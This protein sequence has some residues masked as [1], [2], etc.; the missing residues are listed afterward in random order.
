MRAAAVALLW[1]ATTA[2]AAAA[3]PQGPIVCS[4][5][6][7]VCV[8]ADVVADL[9][10][11]YAVEV[12]GSLLLRNATLR[13]A[14]CDDEACEG[15]AFS[16]SAPRGNITLERATVVAASVNFTALAL[17]VDVNSS[18]AANGMGPMAGDGGGQ[19]GAGVG[20]DGTGGGHGGAGAYVYAC[21]MDVPVAPSSG[22]GY[23]YAALAA[24]FDFGRGSTGFDHPGRQTA[25]RGGGRVWL[26]AQGR[27]LIEGVVSV[28]G[29][30][31]QSVEC[32]QSRV[33]C[34]P[35]GGSG[36]SV[37]VAGFNVTLGP[38]GSLSARGGDSADCGGGGGGLVALYAGSYVTGVAAGTVNVTGGLTLSSAGVSCPVGGTGI[39]YLQHLEE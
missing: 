37:Y 14:A 5:N 30:V 34:G 3:P 16:V 32:S 31:G 6:A 24:P 26:Q 27:A 8:V 19:P 36:G 33:A 1:V 13:G 11:G 23:G 7:T 35:G 25:S 28:D 9:P 21:R 18:I 20:V 2:A 39:Y 17:H 10:W 12:P 38:S 22:Q 15:G 4:P 29:E